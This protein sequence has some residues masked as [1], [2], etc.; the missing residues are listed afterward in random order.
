MLNI[1]ALRPAAVTISLP[2]PPSANE[3]WTP[4]NRHGALRKSD[5]YNKW[6][7]SAGWHCAIARAKGRIPYRYHLLLTVP[8]AQRADLDN[9][10][11][12]VGD[13]LQRQGVVTND[14]HMR[15][16]ACVPSIEQ[17][18]DFCTVELWA[19]DEAP[20]PPKAKRRTRA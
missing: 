7:I 19:T 10:L 11:K 15:A 16:V 14:R 1:W 5:A 3:I 17:R 4:G 2:M 18:P 13:L 20:P 12:P 8:D 9:L 6:L